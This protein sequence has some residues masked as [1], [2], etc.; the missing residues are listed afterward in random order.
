MDQYLDSL[1][2]MAEL[3]PRTLFPA[4]G[5]TVLAAVEKLEEYRRHRLEREAQVLA[6]WEAGQR[7]ARE[8]VAGIY[9]DVPVAV[10]PVAERQVEAHLARLRKSGQL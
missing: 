8:M 1:A 4:H 9:P 7:S 10:H 5:P 2:R 6:A 3:K